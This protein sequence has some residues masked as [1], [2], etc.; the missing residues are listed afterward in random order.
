MAPLTFIDTHNMVAFLTKS[1][2]S[3][4]FD[5]V[6]D[7]LNAHVIQ[8]ALMVNPTIYVSCIK[9]FW[10]TVTIKKVN[11]VVELRTLINRKKVVV[12][13]DI[14]HKDL[15]LD[16]A[17]GVKCLPN[18]E[19]FTELSLLRGLRGTSSVV[20]WHLLSPALLQGVGKGFSGVK[21]PLFASMM[22]PPQP[23]AAEVEEEVKVP[24]THIPSLTPAPSP[25]PQDPTHTP[26][27]SPPSPPQEQPTTTSISS[28]TLIYSLL[29]TYATLSQKVAELEQDKH[30]QALEIIKLKKRVKKLEK[31]RRSKSSG[32]KRLRKIG[33]SQRVKSSADTVVDVGTQVDMDAELQWRIDQDVSAA[34]KDVNATEPTVFDDEE[35]MAGYKMEDF[36]GMTYDKVRPIFEREYKK[37][38]TLFKPDKDVEEPQKK[39]VAEETLLQESFK[40]LKAVEVLD[41]EIHTKGS[42]TYWKIIRVGGIT[43]AYQSFED[44]LKGFDREDWLLYGA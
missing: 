1:N 29:E 10:A 42:R 15:Y 33:T 20:P 11:D 34:T 44:T 36:R 7:F 28:M 5:Q 12:S 24:T 37:V 17:D 19:I 27:A 39:R 3:A 22:A 8:Y 25:P 26:H 41:W 43:K 13:E 31:K 6:V 14:I 32:L 30:T 35:N 40:K 9:K 4:G 38:Q 2:A 16:D 23:Q 18:E 21:T